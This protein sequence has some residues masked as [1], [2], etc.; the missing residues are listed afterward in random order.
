MLYQTDSLHPLEAA[1]PLIHHNCSHSTKHTHTNMHPHN[2]DTNVGSFIIS[3]SS[4]FGIQTNVKSEADMLLVVVCGDG[5]EATEMEQLLEQRKGSRVASGLI[6]CND[7]VTAVMILTKQC[8]RP[9]QNH[10]GSRSQ[11]C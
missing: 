6:S 3:T 10:G 7:L 5:G 8:L 2:P 1:L 9:T 11:A 4:V